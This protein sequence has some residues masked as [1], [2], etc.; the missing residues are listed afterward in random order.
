MSRYPDKSRHQ[1]SPGA[2][3]RDRLVSDVRARVLRGERQPPIRSSERPPNTM[4]EQILELTLEPV[5]GHRQIQKL[6]RS[7][8]SLREAPGLTPWNTGKFDRWA[9]GP[10]PGHG[11]LCG[12]RFVLSVWNS[13][14][15]W[16]CGRFNIHEAML[17]WDSDHRAAFLLWAN[18]PWWA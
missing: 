3:F 1:P 4:I 14:V 9:A 2:L 8:H 16:K 6:A 12:A 17:C 7:F 11:A 18:E 13:A 10:A 5:A 15:A